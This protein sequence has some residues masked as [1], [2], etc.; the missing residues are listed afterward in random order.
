LEDLVYCS[1]GGLNHLGFRG[2]NARI[3]VPAALIEG[4]GDCSVLSSTSSL[5]ITTEVQPSEVLNFG[6]T[7]NDH[8]RVAFGNGSNT[9]ACSATADRDTRPDVGDNDGRNSRL[10]FVP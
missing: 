9:V 5:E 10:Q 6:V 2:V 8:D 4:S 3:N 1:A 7:G